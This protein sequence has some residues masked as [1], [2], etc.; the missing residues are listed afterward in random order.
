MLTT[1]NGL[2]LPIALAVLAS[3][4]RESRLVV[5]GHVAMA[6]AGAAAFYGFVLRAGAMDAAGSH[7]LT[8]SPGMTALYFLAFFAPFLTYLRDSIGAAV[9]A[10]LVTAGAAVV[11]RTLSRG[12]GATRLEQIVAGLLLFAMASGAMAAVGR[13]RFGLDQAA[14]SR[15][16]TFALT[17]CAALLLGLL[18]WRGGRD[19]PM[20]GWI[21]RCAL[22][23]GLCAGLGAH[24]F[25]GLVWRTKA[26][27]VAAAGLAIRAGVQDDEWTETLHPL[28]R[29][30]YEAIAHARA[31]G[32]T[33]LLDPA[34]GTRHPARDVPTCHGAL[35]ASQASRGDAIRIAGVLDDQANHGIIVDATGVVIGVMA[36]APLVAV[37]NP[38]RADV[39][40]AVARAVRSGEWRTARWIGFAAARSDAS[41]T[42]IMRS[43]SGDVCRIVVR[44][45]RGL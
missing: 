16:A 11:V 20:P 30:A 18:E 19:L 33:S 41:M 38:S 32:D 8:V 9:G 17:Y 15:Y 21:W 27:N 31:N 1:S 26:E 6:V 4:R 7:A 44:S 13:A 28:P 34:I 40:R 24:I 37:P 3:A 43:A 35:T 10:V 23:T 14:Q 29:V 5:A 39:T 12:P 45:G 36:R 2:A 22:L 42:A 25:T